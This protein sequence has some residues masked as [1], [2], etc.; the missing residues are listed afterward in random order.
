MSRAE[1]LWRVTLAA[2]DAMAAAAATDALGDLD[3]VS[4]FEEGDGGPWLIEGIARAKPD[5]ASLVARLALAWLDFA[6]PPPELHWDKLPRRDWVGIN[7]AS[8]QPLAVGRFFIHGSHF[9]GRVPSARIALEID[10]ATAFGTGEHATTRGCLAMLDAMA[11]CGPRRTLDMGTGTGILSMAAAKRWRRRIVASDIDPEAV[12]VTAHNIRRNGV[13][14]L[15]AVGR[16][17]GYR[18]RSVMRRRPYDLVLANILARPLERMAADL[19]R[20]LAPGG[21]AVLS[22]LLSYQEP[23]VLAAHR[24]AG[25]SLKQRI[26]ID[27]WS[28][29]ALGRGR[30]PLIRSI[31]KHRSR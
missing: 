8:F 22:G 18:E 13:S 24:L 11:P 17:G 1:G 27:G 20:A 14:R 10:A 3:A 25:L 9:N 6:G 15:I 21:I 26:V 28:T 16:S 7:Q 30:S 12:R 5:R 4:A 19:R 23:G 31:R 2:P 29:L